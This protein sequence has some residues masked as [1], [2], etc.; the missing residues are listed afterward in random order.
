M[1]EIIGNTIATPNPRPD[2]N[3]K[4]ET[5][6]DYIKNKPTVLTEQD[7]IDLIGEH[8]DDAQIQSDW[9]QADDTKLDYIKNKPEEI[10][11]LKGVTSNIQTQLDG[12]AL[13]THAHTKS[14]IGL[15]EVENKSS[16]TIRGELTKENVTNALGYTP[17]VT[18]TVYDDTAIKNSINN[19]ADKNSPDFTG[20]AV[21]TGPSTEVQ[22][23]LNIYKPSGEEDRSFLSMNRLGGSLVG[24]HSVALGYACAATSYSSIAAGHFANAGSG[25]VYGQTALGR[26]NKNDS[27]TNQ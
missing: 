8:G 2:W 22:H 18:D 24:A 13:E 11:Y 6:A 9:N 14:D 17:P 19:K 10:N 1:S 21:F 12:K 5:K 26:F 16:A 15:S 27:N 7:V 4:D 23:G 3:Q 20:T 25:S